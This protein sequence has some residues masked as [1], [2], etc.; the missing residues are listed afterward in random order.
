MSIKIISGNL[1]YDLAKAIEKYETRSPIAKHLI[2]MINKKPK[3]IELIHIYVGTIDALFELILN[4]QKSNADLK[5]A[6]THPLVLEALKKDA[7]KLKK[8]T[9][10]ERKK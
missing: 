1:E 4:L 2:D 5:E 7:A 3:P 9:R 8:E 10:I 6:L